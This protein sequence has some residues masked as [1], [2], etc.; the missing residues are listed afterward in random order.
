MAM[1]PG[2]FWF[3][4]PE[5]VGDPRPHAGALQAAVAAVHQHERRLMVGH[6]GVHRADDAHVVDVPLGRAG[7]ELADLDAALAVLLERERRAQGRAGLA[8]GAEGR[9]GKRLAVVLRQQRLGIKGVDLRRSTVHEQVDDLLGSRGEMRRL[10]RQRA[11]RP[12]RFGPRRGSQAQH[13]VV[14]QDPR[15]P[16]QAKPHA[17]APQQL[18]AV[19]R[20]IR[21]VPA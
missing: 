19:E 8:L 18:A 4:E 2:R 20:E 17:A 9:P 21:I 7:E 5:P 11:K 10:R 14:G 15:Q 13:V 16:D 3:S 6:V 1:K 12:D